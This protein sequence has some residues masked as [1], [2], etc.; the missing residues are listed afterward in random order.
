[1]AF[2]QVVS[3]E[4]IAAAL[5]EAKGYQAAASKIAGCSLRTMYRRVAASPELQAIV[6]EQREL[7]TDRVE[8]KL[9]QLVEKGNVAA[10][11]FYLKTQAKD[12][13]YV[14][15]V[16]VDDEFDD[17]PIAELRKMAQAKIA[18]AEAA[19]G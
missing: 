3:D 14:E 11:I 9:L 8:L 4:K 16:Q 6:E 7:T 15:R 17:I 12:R 1:M 18:E 13:G 10:V 5:A 2:E 19:E